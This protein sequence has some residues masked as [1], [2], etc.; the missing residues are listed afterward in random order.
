MIEP[1]AFL[2]VCCKFVLVLLGA[3]RG[4]AQ[5]LSARS[6]PGTRRRRCQS[7][8]KYTY[9]RGK[10]LRRR[11]G[12]SPAGRQLDW[13]SEMTA[14]AAATRAIGTRKGEQDT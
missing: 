2:W 1:I 3:V 14:L 6:A 10:F 7:L 12:C 13:V 4:S 9:P 11:R 8:P 5:V